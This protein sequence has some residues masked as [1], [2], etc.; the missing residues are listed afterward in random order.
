MALAVEPNTA[1]WIG[2]IAAALAAV[3]TLGA[4]AVLI[5]QLSRERRARKALET[6][7]REREEAQNWQRVQEQASSV[8]AWIIDE[9]EGYSLIAISNAPET[10]VYEAIATQVVRQGEG[11]RRGQ[12]MPVNLINLRA[13]VS[14][15][16]PGTSYAT[17]GDVPPGM[18]GRCGIEIAFNDSSGASWIR[19]ANGPLLHYEKPASEIYGLSWPIPWRSALRN[20]DRAMHYRH[21]AESEMKNLRDLAEFEAKKLPPPDPA[22]PNAPS[23]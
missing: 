13:V 6:R 5:A 21:E 1:E 14:V 20:P 11:P 9:G 16:P 15:V 18:Q 10:P 3:G 22:D 12:D 23:T 4:L 17:I 19:L 2:A 7:D 8:S